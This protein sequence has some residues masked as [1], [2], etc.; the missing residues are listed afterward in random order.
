LL[1]FTQNQT[2]YIYQRLEIMR[3]LV[4]NERWI[5]TNRY[6]VIVMQR[7]DWFTK[8]RVLLLCICS[9]NENLSAG[10]FLIR[11]IRNELFKWRKFEYRK[12][13]GKRSEERVADFV[14][15]I[16]EFSPFEPNNEDQTI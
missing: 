12:F 15:S 10:R 14:F 1:V 9:Y 8:R 3:G 7:N 6:V 2:I 16:F 4:V 13:T 11:A 5:A